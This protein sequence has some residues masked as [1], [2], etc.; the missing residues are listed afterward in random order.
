MGLS[1][2]NPFRRAE[3]AGLC[4]HSRDRADLWLQQ[5]WIPCVGYSAPT[6]IRLPFY[7]F[8]LHWFRIRT[9]VISVIL[10][11]LYYAG[12]GDAVYGELDLYGMMLTV[13]RLSLLVGSELTPPRVPLAGIAAGG[14]IPIRPTAIILVL[15]IAWNVWATNSPMSRANFSVYFF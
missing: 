14:S 12:T 10:S 6:W 5:S 2:T 11:I 4:C 7:R 15:L 8:L 13:A 9:T 3:L 1:R